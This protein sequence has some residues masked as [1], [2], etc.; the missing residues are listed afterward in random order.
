[1]LINII[2]S[3]SKIYRKNI[4]LDSLPKVRKQNKSLTNS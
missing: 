2:L 4:I 3:V 1:M